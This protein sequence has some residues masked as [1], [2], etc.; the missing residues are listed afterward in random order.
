MSSTSTTADLPSNI[1]ISTHPCVR[2][3]LSLLR[4]AS[5]NARDTA[6]LIH[7]IAL[8]VGTEALGHELSTA[9]AGTDTSPLG[10][11]YP[12][13]ALAPARI[14]IMPIMRS[15]LAM[16]DRTSPPPPPP[17]AAPSERPR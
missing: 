7:D 14:S 8:L 5:T 12:V 11:A 10:Y 17:R 1:H 13:D 15:G 9:R 6:A 4:S 3:K 2:A 16:V